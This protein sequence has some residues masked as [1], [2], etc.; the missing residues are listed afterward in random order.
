MEKDILNN[1]KLNDT[2]DREN[3][4]EYKTKW[5]RAEKRLLDI[6][7]RA[8]TGQSIY[9]HEIIQEHQI[10]DRTFRRDKDFINA[11]LADNQVLN[12]GESLEIT[13]N[14]EYN[15]YR[16]NAD[17]FLQNEEMMALVK[18]LIGSRALSYEDMVR[19]I[20]KLSRFTTQEDRALLKKLIGKEK[21][22]YC[23]IH[24]DCHSLLKNHWQLT[25]CIQRG[26]EITIHYLKMDR[27]KI[28]RRIKPLSIIFTDYYFYLIA[29]ETGKEAAAPKYYRI[30]RITEIKKHNDEQLPKNAPNGRAKNFDEEQ[31]RKKSLLM[32]P[33]PERTITFEF[34]GPSLQAVLDKLPTATYKEE[35]GKY[36][37]EAETYGDGIK[38][39][40]LSQGSWVKVLGPESFV[41]EMEEEIEKMKS[42][43]SSQAPK[44]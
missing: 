12:G 18:I 19:I 33:G 9:M 37:V 13:Y 20:S 43:Y 7:F 21:E 29:V 25:K 15:E 34:T 11:F 22:L 24:A 10:S 30:D 14:K 5:E 42:L 36:I 38:M 3:M 32:W 26:R 31:L 41:C 28:R 1:K 17:Y 40:L 39:F 27:S 44:E 6:F 4:D 16:M 8:I 2:D 35:N 23:E